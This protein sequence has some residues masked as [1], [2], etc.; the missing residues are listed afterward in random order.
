MISPLFPCVEASWGSPASSS[1]LTTAGKMPTPIKVKGKGARKRAWAP[2]DPNRFKQV[3]RQRLNDE[4]TL[5][6]ESTDRIQSGSSSASIRPKRVKTK[7]PAALIEQL[8]TEII[9]HIF[10][11]SENLNFPKSSLRIGYILSHPSLLLELTVAA[12]TPTWEVWLGC[13]KPAV[14]SYYGYLDD[15]DRFGG[16][17]DFQSDVLACRWMKVS[18]LHDAQQVWRRRK[19]QSPSA[20]DQPG[21]PPI[22]DAGFGFS[23]FED[24]LEKYKNKLLLEEAGSIFMNSTT[25]RFDFGV[26]CYLEKH[27]LTR[28][29]NHLL[30][31][32]F[33][34]DKVK[35]LFW[36]VRSG[37]IVMPSSSPHY[38]SWEVCFQY[39]FDCVRSFP[40]V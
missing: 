28:V 35:L 16:N 29:P 22:S 26:R 9:E 27:P 36:L 8:P 13:R 20:D 19:W 18:L 38:Q 34:W 11:L 24:D 10:L 33:D 4:D 17:P 39:S 21:A 2:P 7:K 37:A 32:P 6:E 3:K 5:S 40:P 12:F 25:F 23:N 30:T 31:G 1:V 14:Q 15:H